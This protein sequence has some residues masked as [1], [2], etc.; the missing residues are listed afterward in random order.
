MTD[1]IEART[2]SSGQPESHPGTT[3][4]PWLGV[5]FWSRAGGPRM[6]SRYDPRIVR[7]ELDVLAAHGLDVTR[8]FCF[9]PDF[10][11]RPE[12]IDE[13]V[14][15]RFADFLDAHAERGMRTIP[16]F[17]V[18]HMSGE[19]WDP[20]WRLGRD[21]YRDVWMVSQQ[22]WFAGEIARRYGGHAAICGW[23]VSNEM[24]LYGGTGTSEEIAAWARIVVQAV[25]A[26]GAPQPLSLGDGAWGIEVTGADNGYS[27]RRLA[28]LVDFIGP[29]S[30]PMQDDELRQVLSP[31]F[32]CELAAGFGRPVVL[33]EFGV[34]S[35]FAAEDNA[36]AY[37]RQVLHTS[38]LAGARG[39]LAWN[40]TDFDGLRDEDPYRHH[41]FELHFGLT[42][43]NGTAKETLRAMRDFASL[44]RSLP[45]SWEPARRDAAIVVPEHFEREL[46]FS[47]AAYRADIRD[48]L[49]Q[50]YVAAREADLPVGF[51]RERDGLDT[52]A[53]LV[54]APCA[55]L[56]TAPGLDR[57]LQL[58]ED[59]AT[60][61]LSFFAGSTT[62][63]RGPWLSWLP[64]LFGVE[65][66]L[67]Y[68]LIDPI[69]DDEVVLEL[70]ADLG[71]LAAGTRLA[72]TVSGEPSARAHLPVE[73]VGA[74]TVAIDSYGRP[75]L[76]R[77]RLGAGQTVLC[78]YPLEHLAS[79]TPWANPENTWRIYSALATAAGVVRRVSV[80][81]P[82]VLAG[83][84]TSDARDTAVLVNCSS[85]A[86]SLRPVDPHPTGAE[87]TWPLVVASRSAATF[88]LARPAADGDGR[89][90]TL[91]LA[92]SPLTKGGMPTSELRP[93]HE[94][95]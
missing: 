35:D 93:T 64:E 39:W 36:A 84:L 88:P 56:L 63:Q 82:Q 33:E 70:V 46:P 77:H 67:R 55:K 16:T 57:L 89:Q 85:S 11:P 75:A 73:A 26:A 74:E 86:V 49:L 8:S 45:E 51:V 42:D 10:V 37:Y 80:D 32:A 60:V 90:P 19:N 71:D 1:A 54:L 18:G 44:V 68:G 14:A 79:R 2:P 25:R 58:A 61:Y 53:R 50:A 31:A 66:R 12:V 78:T 34:T 15:A 6:W 27:L 83:V 52:G 38:L 29:H 40:N 22:A 30:Y 69:E 91:A 76:L 92:A 3:S 20:A 23:L 24:P 87:T 94:A 65:H 9:W 48:Q 13:D 62:N 95:T 41:V 72:F 4:Y 81:D 7:D 28:P 59:G 5:N 47:D 17:L 21:L 43:A